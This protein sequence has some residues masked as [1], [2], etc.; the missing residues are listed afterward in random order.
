MSNILVVNGVVL[1]PP[2][3]MTLEDYDITK[4]TRNANGIMIMEMVRADVH[5]IVCSWNYLRPDKY[6]IIRNAIRNKYNL[7]VKYLIP[8]QNVEG[9]IQ[10]YVGDRSTP[11][12]KYGDGNPLYKDFSV[13]FIEM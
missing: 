3:K 11:V 7:S 6:I 10:C 5:K 2:S 13:N 1:P 12:Y 8:E 4:A 9:I